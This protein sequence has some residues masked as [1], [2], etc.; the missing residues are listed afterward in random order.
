MGHIAADRRHDAL[1]L[2]RIEKPTAPKPTSIIAQVVGSGIADAVEKTANVRFDEPDVL[3][4]RA[5]EN[6]RSCGGNKAG[7]LIGLA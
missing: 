3:V 7:V 2:H 4:A 1:A 5:I 6:V